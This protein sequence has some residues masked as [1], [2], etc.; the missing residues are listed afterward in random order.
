MA[1]KYLPQLSAELPWVEKAEDDLVWRFFT[2][3]KTQPLCTS[4]KL[5]LG[6]R[7]LGE[8]EKNSFNALPGKRG[9]PL[10]TM[11]LQ[12]QEDVVRFIPMEA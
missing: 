11:Y 3:P 1:L 5:N 4:A 9:V 2:M 7:V 6:G 8:A 10:K 12:P